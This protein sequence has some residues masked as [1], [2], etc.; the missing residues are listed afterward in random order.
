[1]GQEEGPDHGVRGPG[2]WPIQGLFLRYIDG[3]QVT[4]TGQHGQNI[5]RTESG[6]VGAL[7]TL[8][9]LDSY[10]WGSEPPSHPGVSDVKGQD[11][12]LARQCLA[13]FFRLVVGV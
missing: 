11:R 9:H 6:R 4:G 5:P 3:A 7:E 10:V 2:I 8:D 12:P 1:V 13:R